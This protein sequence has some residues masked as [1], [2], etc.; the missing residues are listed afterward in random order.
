M[1]LG[2]NPWHRALP[3]CEGLWEYRMPYNEVR[4]VRILKRHGELWMRCEMLGNFALS[5]IEAKFPETEWR[6]CR[7]KPSRN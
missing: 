2:R 1:P 7:L 6:L 5:V 4:R 3:E